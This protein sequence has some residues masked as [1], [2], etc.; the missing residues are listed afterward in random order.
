VSSPCP[1][2]TSRLPP[3]DTA[4]V[5]GK[6]STYVVNDSMHENLM[7]NLSVVE[8]GEEVIVK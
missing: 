8:D 5:I 4:I 7:A 1:L 3:V 2:R 6:V